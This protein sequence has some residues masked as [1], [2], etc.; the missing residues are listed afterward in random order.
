MK[1]LR[2]QRPQENT[3]I[4]EIEDARKKRGRLERGVR[5]DANT[6]SLRNA[7]DIKGPSIK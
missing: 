7:L 6:D 5:G 1:K 2:P 4:R 3:K